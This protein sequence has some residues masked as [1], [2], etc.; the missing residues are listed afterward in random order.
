MLHLD[1]AEALQS[2][3]PWQTVLLRDCSEKEK[4]EVYGLGSYCKSFVKSAAE[5]EDE[6]R[7]VWS[8]KK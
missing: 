4:E 3:G 5:W 7:K 2:D 6:R 1:Q 8:D